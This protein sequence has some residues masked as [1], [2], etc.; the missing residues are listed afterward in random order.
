MIKLSGI[1]FFLNGKSVLF[2]NLNYPKLSE[3]QEKFNRILVEPK[4]EP[5]QISNN[6]TVPISLEP[7]IEK[8]QTGTKLKT[9][10]QA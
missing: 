1:Y 2:F 3:K 10:R 4:T 7:K 5:N 8:N 6:Q 9:K